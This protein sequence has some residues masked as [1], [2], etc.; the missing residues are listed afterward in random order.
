VPAYSRSVSQGNPLQVINNNSGREPNN[1]YQI[2][3]LNGAVHPEGRR[4]LGG[5]LDDVHSGKYP[6]HTCPML[7]VCG[8]SC[9]K[10]WLEGQVPCPSAKL[11]IEQRML[12]AWMPMQKKKPNKISH[13]NKDE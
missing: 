7:P 10:L 13:T 5:F 11:N 9:P 4:K 2:G 12:L 1:V 6:C 8:G 3:D